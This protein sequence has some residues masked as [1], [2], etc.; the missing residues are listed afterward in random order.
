MFWTEIGSSKISNFR[1]P[2]QFTGAKKCGAKKGYV[3]NLFWR[4]KK[5]AKKCCAKKSGAKLVLA[6]KSAAPNVFWRQN[7]MVPVMQLVA[8]LILALHLMVSPKFHFCSKNFLVL[9]LFPRCVFEAMPFGKR[10]FGPK[11]I[12]APF[13]I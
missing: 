7:G 2:K 12:L 10:R 9:Y 3:S 1:A 4:Q 13:F 8:L 11:F 5:Y 6:P